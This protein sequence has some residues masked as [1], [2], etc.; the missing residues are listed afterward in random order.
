[1]VG[2]GLTTLNTVI[3]HRVVRDWVHLLVGYLGGYEANDDLVSDPRAA[4]SAPKGLRALP[5]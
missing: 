3:R 4:A 2:G 1:M 5:R